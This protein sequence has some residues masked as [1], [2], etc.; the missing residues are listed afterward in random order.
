MAGS[1]SHLAQDSLGHS[2]P[3]SKRHL[4]RFSRFYTG[5]RQV[6]L[7]F[8]MGRPFLPKLPIPI[9]DLTH[10]SLGP[11]ELTKQTACRSV[12]PSLQGSLVILFKILALY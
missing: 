5:D 6:S 2:E 12:Q 10:A 4:D 11:S 7:H 8:S 9:G 1:G 3:T